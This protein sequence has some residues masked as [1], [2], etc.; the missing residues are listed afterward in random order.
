MDQPDFESRLARLEHR[1]RILVFGLTGCTI[2][3]VIALGTAM[4]ALVPILRV[5]SALR[6]AFGS[7]PTLAKPEAA[8]E[9]AAAQRPQSPDVDKL[10]AVI[11]VTVKAKRLLPKDYQAGRYHIGVELSLLGEN[12]SERAL[13]AYQGTLDVE[14][15]LGNR[16]ILLAVQ[17]QSPLDPHRTQQFK[18]YFEINEFE[19]RDTRFAAEQFNNLVFKWELQKIVF[20][21]GTEI[22]ATP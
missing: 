20:A 4:R 7:N 16:I 17:N 15:V 8:A 19:N 13:R 12:R 3:A 5:Q 2:V 11:G 6:S 14:D 22:E 18:Q 21:D 9:P 10:L 1:N